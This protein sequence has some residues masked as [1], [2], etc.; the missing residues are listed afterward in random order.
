MN[1][2]HFCAE[3]NESPG[4]MHVF[5]GI[6]TSNADVFDKRF[7]DQLKAGIADNM[8]P[9]RPADRV[10]LRSLSKLA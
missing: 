2:Y 4:V 6:V 1:A 10:V 9:P 3:F 8:K 5:D 7:Y